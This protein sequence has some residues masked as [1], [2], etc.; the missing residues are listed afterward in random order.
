MILQ[1]GK[2]RWL[3]GMHWDAF[4]TAPSI[5]EIKKEAKS[6]GANMYALRISDLA[7]QAG[8]FSDEQF[9]KVKGSSRLYSL[10]ARLAGAVAEPWFGVFDLG[11]GAY[12]YIAVRDGYSILPDGDK[13][14]SFDEIEAARA[15]H[16]GFN[17]WKTVNGSIEDLESLLAE[18]AKQE[19]A[20]GI[21]KIKLVPVEY[22]GQKTIVY[23]KWM[24]IAGGVCVLAGGLS[25]WQYEDHKKQEE[26][27]Q[28][29][30][31][32][33]VVTQEQNRA[34]APL[35]SPLPNAWLSSCKEILFATPIV[36]DGWQMAN[37]SCAGE[38]AL[39]EWRL[40]PGATVR[41]R[42]A[43]ALSSD[44]TIVSQTLALDMSK[45]VPLLPSALPGPL[46]ENL[47][48]LRFIAQSTGMTLDLV[49]SEQSNSNLPGQ[50][51]AAVNSAADH[52][53]GALQKLKN[54]P[55]RLAMKTSPFAIDFDSVAGLRLTKISSP[56]AS[57]KGWEIEG[58]VYGF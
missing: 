25:L 38:Q 34:L 46:P 7:V 52:L 39:L 31:R 57:D 6:M 36:Q 2:T 11:D 48:T 49:A 20:S 27:R 12:W 44:G 45:L 41:N 1:I 18:I 35:A 17:D 8:Y 33:R 26:L 22:F 9:P 14:G 29:Q 56:I 50:V 4:D 3:L 47:E 58:V 37:V 43:G 53:N 23:A 42:P 55:F 54:Q 32:A 16:A 40:S 15:N 28:Q 51:S 30:E 10:A 21:K 13:V 24:G 19:Q 5:G